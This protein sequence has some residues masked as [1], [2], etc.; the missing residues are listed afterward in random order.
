MIYGLTPLFAFSDT[1][2]TVKEPAQ[3]TK[4]LLQHMEETMLS[5]LTFRNERQS[6]E[7]RDAEAVFPCQ[8]AG[9]ITMQLSNTI[10]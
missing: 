8:Q 4:Q 10:H 1:E 7:S 9:R 6:P 5:N 2:I 3:A